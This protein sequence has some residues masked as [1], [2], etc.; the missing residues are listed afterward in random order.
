LNY[1]HRALLNVGIKPDTY[2]HSTSPNSGAFPDIAGDT[3][4][5]EVAVLMIPIVKE[6]ARRSLIECLG[7][8]Q[9]VQKV[10]RTSARGLCDVR[11][12]AAGKGLSAEGAGGSMDP[13]VQW[14]GR[15]RSPAEASALS[16]KK[17]RCPAR[18][19]GLV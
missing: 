15:R 7:R 5:S 6:A 18:S 4:V 19:L 3:R 11:S 9:K 12:R 13:F 10:K 1:D 17:L 2:C 16:L 14:A 8:F